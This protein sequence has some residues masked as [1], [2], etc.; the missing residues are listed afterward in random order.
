MM[1]MM[2]MY[3]MMMYLDHVVVGDHVGDEDEYLAILIGDDS[4]NKMILMIKGG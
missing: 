4:S 1:M 3:L 2:M